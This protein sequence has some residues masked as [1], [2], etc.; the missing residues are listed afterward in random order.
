[1]AP[2]GYVV[3]DIGNRAGYFQANLQRLLMYHYARTPAEIEI[4]ATRFFPERI[5]RA[6]RFGGRTPRAIIFDSYVNPKID[7]PAVAD[8]LRWFHDAGM[9]LYSTWP[10]L[11]PPF[12]ADAAGRETLTRILSHPLLGVIPELFWL[13]H[14]VDDTDAL[15]GYWQQA[16]TLARVMAPVVDA[17]GDVTPGFALDIPAFETGVRRLQEA[18][19]AIASHGGPLPVG[20]GLDVLFGEICG[21][22]ALLDRRADAE[23]MA[24]YLRACK[25]L[26]RGTH[27]VGSTQYIGYRE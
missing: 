1:V 10:P 18:A 22:L 15:A 8:V 4:L 26:F 27:G 5:E 14:T 17:I 2:G 6:V 20:A 24:A 16:E 13:S 11:W 25:V 23:A 21:M 3:L 19:E 9:A 7:T 12:L